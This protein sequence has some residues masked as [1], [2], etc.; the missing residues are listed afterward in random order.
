MRKTIVVTTM[1]WLVAL[2]AMIFFTIDTQQEHEIDYRISVNR[3]QNKFSNNLEENKTII[4]S[5]SNEELSVIENIHIIDTSLD[6]ENQLKSFFHVDNAYEDSVVFMPIENTSFIVRFNLKSEID[7][8]GQLL[9]LMGT[10][11]TLAYLFVVAN[12]ILINRNIIKPMERLSNITN[13]IATGYIGEINLQHKNAYFNDFIWSLDMLREQLNHQKEK[14]TE[15]EKQRKTLVAGLSH[16]IRTPLSSVKNYTIALKEGVYE[17]YDDKDH[18]LDVILEKADVIERLT[19]DLLESSL[20][21]IGEI[22]VNA[23]EVYFLN[24]HQQLNRI[25]H[26]KIDLLHMKYLEPKMAENL[27]LVVDMDRLSE[28]FDNIIENALKYGDMQSISVVYS[29]E[30]HFQLITISNTGSKIPETEI[31]HIFTSYFR[32]SNVSDKPGYGLGLYISKQIMKKMNGDIF[33]RNTEAGVS[34]V[35]VIKQAG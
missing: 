24:V 1:L 11:I 5:L 23:K 2:V 9:V 19:K 13:K 28:V 35:I 20:K 14:N 25:I 4:N 22:D 33:A 6:S 16:D 3:I 31:K 32:G 30:E 29:T 7:N 21:D 34:F 18:A 8:R 15:L 27:M 12:T 17:S 26:E 10:I